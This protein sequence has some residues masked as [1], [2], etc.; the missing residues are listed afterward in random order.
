MIN[1]Y[2]CLRCKYN[3][4]KL[5]NIKYHLN[6]K[7]KCEKTNSESLQYTDEEIYELSFIRVHKRNDVK[8]DFCN[9]TYS[10]KK[11][12]YN[13]QK[14]FCKE[15]INKEIINQTN[16]NIETQNN[17][18]TQNNFDI[19]NNNINSNTNNIININIPLPFDKDWDIEHI[20]NYLKTVLYLCNN[21][22]TEFLNNVMK[23]KV[24]LNVVCDKEMN[25]AYIFTDNEY[26]NIEKNELFKKSMEK[27]YNHL[28]KIKEEFNDTDSKLIDPNIINKEAEN[29][30][31]K[32]NNYLKDDEIKDKVHDCLNNI[33]DSNKKE[34]YEI[35]KEY[36]GN[37]ILP[38]F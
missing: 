26:K 16:I 8:C 5:Y 13:H 7:K 4:D 36:N 20:D 21:K 6:K 22:F 37:A 27:I 15:K 33:Y 23:N 28:T 29:I 24:N 9:K 31:F 14:K 25:D 1:Q 18:N 2:E 35:F 10:D 17:I 12:L 34:A 38:G 32:Y 11:S 19:I 30:N 3:T